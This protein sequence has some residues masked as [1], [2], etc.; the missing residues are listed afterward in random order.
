MNKL[1]RFQTL[2][3]Q[4]PPKS[5]EWRLYG[6]GIEN[7]GDDKKPCLSDLPDPA[8]DEIL[9]RNDAIGLCFSDAKIIRLGSDHPRI[10]GR[11][12]KAEPVI[13]GH[14]VSLTVVKAGKERQGQ[15]KPG[16]RYVIQADVYY[17]G[18]ATTYG[19]VLPGGLS[20]YGIIGKEILDGDEGSYLLPIRKEEIGYSEVALVEPWACV[21]ASYRIEQR[22]SVRNSGTLLVVGSEKHEGDWDFT[23]LFRHAVPRSVI[24]ANL[25]ETLEQ[26]IREAISGKDVMLIEERTRDVKH[27]MTAHTGG[28]GFDD[29]I[30][31]GDTET[32]MLEQAA[33]SLA[34]SGILNYMATTEDPQTVKIDAGKIHYD[35]ISFLGSLKRDVNAPYT[36]NLDYRLKGNSLLLLGAGGPMGQMHVQLALESLSPSANI[37]ATD[38]ADDRI[39]VLVEKFGRIAKERGVHFHVLK[40]DDFHDQNDYRKELLRLNNNR[41]YDYVVCLAALPKVIEDASSYLGFG[42][43]LNIFAGVSRGTIVRLNIK[44]TASKSVRYIGSSGSTIKDMEY[45]LRKVEGGELN[46][47]GS[48]AGISGMRDVWRGIEAVKNGTFPGKIVVYPHI[49]NMDLIT[50]KELEQKYPRIG[51]LLSEEG[52]WTREA[53]SELLNRML[54]LEE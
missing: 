16:E 45:T 44:E 26:R 52:N 34:P 25:G 31:L 46:T 39:Q 13:P 41:L 8:D 20:Q 19:Y 9:V 1:I 17:R 40:P 23:S 7:F 22:D 14:E 35:R 3:Y 4:I 43:V 5:L 30:L 51:R 6:R 36:E 21:V 29:I 33:G 37:V 53:E 15:Y 11:E 48:V 32:E 28:K 10:Q 24:F 18:K 27:L 42:S 50:M 38:I 12:L 49:G 54:E 2:D 47:N